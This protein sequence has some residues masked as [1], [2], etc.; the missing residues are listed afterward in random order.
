M[1]DIPKPPNPKTKDDDIEYS[2]ISSKEDDSWDERPALKRDN[3]KSVADTLRRLKHSQVSTIETAS[4][5]KKIR[6]ASGLI[7]ETDISKLR[8]FRKSIIIL[9]LLIFS[10]VLTIIFRYQQNGAGFD[11]NQTISPAV[12]QEKLVYLKPQD[13]IIQTIEALP[14][15]TSVFVESNNQSIEE[16]LD[17]IFASL[18]FEFSKAFKISAQSLPALYLNQTNNNFIL[19]LYTSDKPLSARDLR[20]WE[21]NVSSVSTLLV[22]DRS[23]SS[24]TDQVLGEN[25]YRVINKSISYTITEE[26][27][28][29][30]GSNPQ[31]IDE[32]SEGI[33]RAINEGRQNL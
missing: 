17:L 29:L 18:G 12:P 30:I 8:S 21:N 5:E 13:N 1:I 25:D 14:I 15:S 32:N 19:G 31:V 11:F 22:Q 2:S 23:F 33:R 27:L 4:G 7:S 28:I 24:T 10:I 16:S 6:A 3:Q 20:Q 26:G 9:I